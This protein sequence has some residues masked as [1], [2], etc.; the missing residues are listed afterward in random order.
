MYLASAR[1]ILLKWFKSYL[2]DRSQYVIGDGVKSETKSVE[3]GDPQ[4]SIL[5]PLF[6]IILMN[7]IC[8]VSD[9]MF[10][11]MYADDTCFLMDSTDVLILEPSCRHSKEKISKVIGILYRLKN[12][13]P[14]ETLETLYNSLIASYLN[15]GLLLWGTE[16]HKVFTLQ[17]KAIRLISNSSYICH[18]NQLFI[19]LKSR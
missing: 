13:F 7:D 19:K 17:K 10:A 12:T 9:L 1:G 14:L 2:A 16:S 4:G 18:T 3:C 8:N 6:F 5:G 11:I 15:Y